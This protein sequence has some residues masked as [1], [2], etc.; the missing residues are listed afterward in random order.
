MSDGFSDGLPTAS[1]PPG[2]EAAW[3]SAFVYA[4]YLWPLALILGG[5]AGALCGFG[6]GLAKALSRPAPI[7]AN[8]TPRRVGSNHGR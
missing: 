3:K 7:P 5:G 1:L 8:S 4:M 6:T 2:F